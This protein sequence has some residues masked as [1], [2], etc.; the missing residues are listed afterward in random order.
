MPER[1][2]IDAMWDDS[3]V[4][5]SKETS[6][7]WSIANKLRGTYQSDKYKE[8]IIPMTIIRRFEC[9]LAATKDKVLAL[10]D[11]NPNY[12]PKA[13]CKAAGFQFYN[14]SRFTLGE[15][16]ND[17]DHLAP[18]FISYIEGFSS[19]VQ[20]ILLSEA[21]G[22]DFGK[23]I[24]KMD[25][26]N[27]LLAVVKAF[28]ELDLDPQTI[29]N[30]KMGYIFE[31]LIRRFSEN[32]EAGDHYT[33]RDIIKLMV[34]ILLSEGCDD[35]F[36]DGKIITI[37]D[38]ACGTGGMLSTGYNFIK[39]YN[40][41]AD[42]ILFGQEIN[43]ESYA[44][45]L[46]EMLIKGQKEENIRYQDTM[47]ADCFPDYKMRFVLENPPFGQAWG[48]KDAA[49]GVEAAVKDEYAK[50]FD[51]RWGA[52]LP[53][54]GDMQMLFLQSA[55][56]K[57]DDQLGRCAIIENGSP[58]FTGG[59][60]S[61][62]SQ[63][64]RWLLEND[65]IEAIIALPT[66]LFYNT[67]I[68]TYIWILSKNK[69]QERKGKVQ[70]IDAS[71]ICHPLRKSLGNKR[72]E[73]SPEDRR[74]ITRLYA[75]F[76]E[77]EE[78][79]IFDNTEF[80]YREYA[81]MQPLQRR[82]EITAESIDRMLQKGSLNSLYDERK[83]LVLQAKQEK[84]ELSAKEARQLAKFLQNQPLYQKIMDTL[85]ANINDQTY[86]HP[87]Y[88]MPV[89]TAALADVT[90]DKKLLE[91]IA[92]GLS[93]MDKTAEIQKDKKGNTLYDKETK[94]T[95]I[96]KWGETI[97]D[98]MAREVLPFVPD[99]K[100]FFEEDL[101]K[102]KPVIKTGAEIPFTRYFYKYQQPEASEKLAQEFMDLEKSVNERI[103]KL[104]GK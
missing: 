27:R 78:V 61:G 7:I 9:A 74:A 32:A 44:M 55:V 90:T 99:A 39:R 56:N 100:A 35:I 24:T 77:G 102:K 14:T 20:E 59:T 16:C 75:D 5:V 25:K 98:Y 63:I 43:P 84:D 4:D 94:D 30:V 2:I 11:K 80:I 37:L 89:L 53:G 46:A 85:R 60:A 42:V 57:M 65:L 48:G 92:D 104:F 73:I 6:M 31:D 22:L 18:N 64:R 10:Y 13:L 40:P 49:E 23:Q 101:S 21:R 29:D 17:P 87:R 19:N 54:T 81:V 67:G 12:P 82:Y 47:K 86:P 52:G 58:L 15:L 68:A 36:D 69:R 95:E 26:N 97:D 96:V 51:G 79:R 34:N 83:V 93:I 76:K 8:V 71:K 70:L 28:S 50:G 62:E 1:Q 72:N 88:F 3:P 41:T 91:K 66:D 33:G 103:Q 38:Q 45:C